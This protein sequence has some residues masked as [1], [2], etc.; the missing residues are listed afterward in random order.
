MPTLETIERDLKIIRKR[1]D[2]LLEKPAKQ[3]WVGVSVITDLTGW[4]GREKLRWAREN[5]LVKFDRDKGYL[6]ESIPEIYIIKKN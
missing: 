6:L 4:E 1:I 3:T 5:G 2:L